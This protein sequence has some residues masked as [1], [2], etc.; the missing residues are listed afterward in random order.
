[1]K[2][3]IVRFNLRLPKKVWAQLKAKAKANK[4]SL[5]FTIVEV[6][7]ASQCKPK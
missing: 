6:L 7:E 3:E 1:M 4:R 2:A 5:N